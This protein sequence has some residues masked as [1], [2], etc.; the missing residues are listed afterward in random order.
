MTV[1]SDQDIKQITSYGL[2]VS[3]AESQIKTFQHGFDFADLVSAATVG[4]G[5]LETSA[6]Q[7]QTLIEFFDESAKS[8]K[9]I[10]FVPASGAATRMFKDF[11]DFLSTGL[12]NKSIDDAISNIQ[13]FAFYDE[14]K[15]H[16][17]QNPT[18]KEIINYIVSENG[19][20]YG[21]LP[22]A[23]IT[24]HKYISE[25]RTALEEHLVEGAQ[26]ASSN[27]ISKIH[28]TISPEHRAGFEKLLS[29]VLPKYESRFGI[30]YEIEMSEQKPSTDTIA[31]NPDNT[32]FR[33]P[34][35]KLLFRPAGHGALIE[36]L[37]D[38]DA[39][40]IF[41]KNI[42]NV[43]TDNLR[44]DTTEYKKTIAG[45]MLDLQKKSFLYLDAIDNGNANL[46]QIDE[47]LK[48][49]LML[50]IPETIDKNNLLDFYKKILNRP[51][52]VCG[53]VKNQG[54]PGGGPFWVKNKDNEVSLQIIESSQI[55]DSDKKIMADATHFNPVDLVCGTKD[56]KGKKF[57]LVEYIDPDTGFISEKSKDGKP[58]RAMERPGLWNGAMAK[59]NTIF[60]EVPISTFSP[61]KVI[62]DLLRTQHQNS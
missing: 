33:E 37:N 7:R 6:K 43:T 42:D 44:L 45:L 56:Y 3:E 47:F 49:E 17:G 25:T 61:V 38:L 51:I 36:N 48:N 15:K 8:H 41:I 22:K 13:K 50:K 60:V 30:K 40:I 18:D 4:N 14:L 26:Y 34:D 39:D 5:I 27:G 62:N 20:N 11:F 57:N 1:F 12:R 2:S 23:L 9:I 32:L 10:K 28:F 53:M 46:D 16:F 52:R 55:A 24:F 35:G 21:A 54:E 58:L 31:V 19:L 29:L 59:W